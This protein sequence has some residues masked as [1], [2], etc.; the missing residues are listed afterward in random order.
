MTGPTGAGP[1]GNMGQYAGY[2]EP[3]C[4]NGSVLAVRASARRRGVVGRRHRSPHDPGRQSAGRL[5]VS[6]RARP[7]PRPASSQPADRHP[8]REGVP[9]GRDGPRPHG[10]GPGD[11]LRHPT[12]PP[13]PGTGRRTAAAAGR[14]RPA[15][16]VDQHA[17]DE[18]RRGLRRA[19]D[20]GHP[21]GLRLRRRQRGRDRQGGRRDGH[22]RGPDDG[23]LPVDAAL[24]AALDHRHRR[25][26]RADRAAADPDPVG[27][28]GARPRVRP[29]PAA[30]APGDPHPPRDRLRRLQD[31]DPAAPPQPADGR[32]RRHE[33]PRLP[34]L[35]PVQPGGGATTRQQL[36]DQGHPLLP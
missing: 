31:A 10:P 15:H 20:R 3:R 19:A 11:D 18:R 22:H 6:H 17:P 36:P 14:R 30:A 24:P 4:G 25:P 23:G 8:R 35:P 32:D 2:G 34:A 9:S 27:A 7:A 29:G 26:D 28:G 16:A 21:D 13:R 33:H 12:R 5:P 1:Y